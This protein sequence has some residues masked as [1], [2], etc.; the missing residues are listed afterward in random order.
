GAEKAGAK[1]KSKQGWAEDGNGTN[2]SGFSGLPGG[3]RYGSG[4]F[5]DVGEDGYWWS[6]SEN[7]TNSAWNRTLGYGLGDVDRCSFNKR[8]GFSVRCLR[9]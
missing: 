9:D 6:S 1:M 8:Y 5:N 7:N 3:T 2:S 4:P